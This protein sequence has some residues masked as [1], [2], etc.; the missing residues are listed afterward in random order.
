M[1]SLLGAKKTLRWLQ[2]DD[3]F[4]ITNLQGTQNMQCYRCVIWTEHK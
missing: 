1:P 3:V 4:L 2:S